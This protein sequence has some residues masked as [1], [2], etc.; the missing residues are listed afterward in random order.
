MNSTALNAR[1]NAALAH[2][3]ATQAS[4]GLDLTPNQRVALGTILAMPQDVIRDQIVATVASALGCTEKVARTTITKMESKGIIGRDGDCLQLQ[5]KYE[6]LR[7]PEPSAGVSPG[8]I[9]E[10][11][12]E[13]DAEEAS[14]KD[15]ASDCIPEVEELPATELPAAE[16]PE[17]ILC[18]EVVEPHVKAIDAALAALSA[19]GLDLKAARRFLGAPAAPKA[20][21][22]PSAPRTPAAPRAPG[23]PRE[24]SSKAA[25]MAYFSSA[26]TV[27][28][29]KAAFPDINPITINAVPRDA[30]TAGTMMR[31][32]RGTYITTVAWE[33]M[34]EEGRSQLLL[35][36]AAER[37]PD[38]D[39]TP[40]PKTPRATRAPRNAEPVDDF[41]AA[42]PTPEAAPAAAPAG[43]V[44]AVKTFG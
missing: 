17:I 34:T 29:A 41:S 3:D 9:A 27:A 40:A 2:I 44:R 16:E 38:S 12:A 26:H 7:L 14:A 43:R 6:A 15:P 37:A 8:L 33:A 25:L 10:V 21:R 35:D 42:A 28:E 20:A 22:A 11:A 1:F 23:A 13:L 24:G 5:P 18:I 4:V 32:G 31:L 19:M 39:A 36:L 30:T